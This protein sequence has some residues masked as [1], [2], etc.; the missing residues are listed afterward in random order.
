MKVFCIVILSCLYLP[1][2]FLVNGENNEQADAVVSRG[3]VIPERVSDH[4]GDGIADGQDNC[5]HEVNPKQQDVDADG[6]GDICDG[7]DDHDSCFD[8]ED[9]CALV[10]NFDQA[11]TDE[12][13]L[14]DAC[15]P[16]SIWSHFWIPGWNSRSGREHC[17]VQYGDISPT[18][19]R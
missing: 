11:D 7:N 13:G 10:T 18:A 3:V 2:C 17:Q 6:Q 8:S 9:N 14:G 1:A 12:D 4:D 15:D 19:N 5:P 16:D